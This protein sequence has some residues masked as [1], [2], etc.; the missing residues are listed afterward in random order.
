MKSRTWLR[1]AA[2]LTLFQA[3]GH[4]FGAVL[5]PPTQ[6]AQEAALRESMRAYRVVA[7]GM[8]RSYWDFYFGSGWTIT[9]FLLT[10]AAVL[11]TVGRIAEDA[12]GLARPVVAVLGI[13]YGAVTVVCA[14]FFVTA[15]IVVA[16]LI[17]ICLVGAW[18]TCRRVPG[19]A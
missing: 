13:G 9:V 6:G 11:W 5:A 3:V 12:P 10:I 7:M 19:G 17:T 2:G 14:L 1:I 18:T 4:T 15:P 16:A 8:E